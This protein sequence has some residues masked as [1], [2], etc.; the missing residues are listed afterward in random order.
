MTASFAPLL[1][2][3]N[4]EARDNYEKLA[5]EALE[6]GGSADL[7]RGA[8]FAQVAGLYAIASMLELIEDRLGAIEERL[9]QAND[10]GAP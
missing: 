4:Q 9:G 2:A 5:V 8:A 7:A 10:H 3:T 6:G 1:G